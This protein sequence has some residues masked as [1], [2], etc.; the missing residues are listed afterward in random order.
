MGKSSWGFG[1][2][3]SIL[4]FALLGATSA[5]AGFGQPSPGQMG[6]QEAVTEVAHGIHSFHDLVN[7]III[8]IAIFVGVLMLV[9]IFR[10][11]AKSNPTPSRTTHHTMLEVAWTVVPILVL[12]VIA[13]PSFKLLY[14]QYSYPKPDL[15]IKAVGNTWFWEHEYPDQGGFRVTSNVVRDEDLLRK[16][17]GQE[18]FNKRYGNLSGAALSRQLHADAAPLW[19]KSGQ[20]RLLSVDNEIAVPVNK[21]VHVL[22][23]ANDVIH[24]WTIPS[25][26]SKV[27]A[28]PGRI[29]ATWFKAERPGVYYGQCSEL[30]GKD[31]AFMPIAVRVVSEEAFKNWVEAAKARE[32]DRARSILHAATESPAD[33]GKVAAAAADAVAGATGQN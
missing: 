33:A 6:M 19:H 3:F 21:V 26:G 5:L 17:L 10:F 29:T 25:F 15:T 31:H 13:I 18:E 28:V 2:L 24:N 27:D 8:A 1:T 16:E 11:N 12:V 9:V 20:P 23:T 7:Y 14:L 30:C 22:V 32:W 4:A